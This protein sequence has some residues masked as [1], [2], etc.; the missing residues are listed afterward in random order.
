[1][2]VKLNFQCP[3][4]VLLEQAHLC[5][6]FFPTIISSCFHAVMAELSAYNRDYRFQRSEYLLSNLLQ[7][8]LPTSRFKEKV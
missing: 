6:F 4:I 1:M 8:N 2:Y 7:K 3:D 5:L